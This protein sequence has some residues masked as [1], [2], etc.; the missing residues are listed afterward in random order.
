[1]KPLGQKAYNSRPPTLSLGIEPSGE[2]GNA[3][4][5]PFHFEHKWVMIRI[6]EHEKG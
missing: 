3:E 4:T 5:L 6:D 2:R 1:M